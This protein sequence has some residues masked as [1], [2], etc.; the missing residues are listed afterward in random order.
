[1]DELIEVYP[2]HVTT[3]LQFH[4]WPRQGGLRLKK[5]GG[6]GKEMAM[7][8]SIRVKQPPCDHRVLTL[9]RIDLT[10]SVERYACMGCGEHVLRALKPSVSYWLAPGR[11]PHHPTAKN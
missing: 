7:K 10:R 6:F 11:H 4:H 9:R 5:Y 2:H 8:I 1:M 3:P